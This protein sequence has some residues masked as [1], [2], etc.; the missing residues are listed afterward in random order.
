ME[1]AILTPEV[2]AKRWS[3]SLSTVAR[4]RSEGM[5]PVLHHRKLRRPGIRPTHP[6]G[7]FSRNWQDEETL[8]VL[9]DKLEGGQLNQKQALAHIPKGFKGQIT[10]GEVENA[11]RSSETNPKPVANGH[12]CFNETLSAR[13]ERVT[14]GPSCAWHTAPCWV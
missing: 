10:W 12:T 3:I 5:G 8:D 1:N 14:T 6:Y 13:T 2:L 11:S 7:R 9:I 4:W